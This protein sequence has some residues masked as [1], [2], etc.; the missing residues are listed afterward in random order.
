MQ[1]WLQES[2]APLLLKRHLRRPNSRL[3]RSQR[4]RQAGPATR[5]V[6]CKWPAIGVNAAYRGL[7][8]IS[9]HFSRPWPNTP[10]ST[11]ARLQP[12]LGQILQHRVRRVTVA[13]AALRQQHRH[14]DLQP[15]LR[16]LRRRPVLRL[17]A[18]L[19]RA[20][21]ILSRGRIVSRTTAGDRNPI[22]SKLYIFR[23]HVMFNLE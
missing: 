20:T 6:Y 12:P 19:R 7:A 18:G 3:T 9:H 10:Q 17:A 21:K 2:A 13:L 16:Q 8:N 14:I 23:T 1:R 5:A 22:I 15:R 4:P 11:P